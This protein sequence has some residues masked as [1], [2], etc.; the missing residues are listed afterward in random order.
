M[1]P[2][3]LAR[4]YG[5]QL[6]KAV[7]PQKL[8]SKGNPITF[9]TIPQLSHTAKRTDAQP[10]HTLFPSFSSMSAGLYTHQVARL[11]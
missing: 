5:K 4:K 7:M 8:L 1:L 9:K 10:L 2:V 11:P 3:R 6:L